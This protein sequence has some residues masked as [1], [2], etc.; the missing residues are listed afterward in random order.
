M[1]G[2]QLDV[3]SAYRSKEYQEKVMNEIIKEKG[4]EYARKYVAVPGY[5]EHQTG[6]AID[7]C[8]KRGN[9]FIY[10]DDLLG[11]GVIEFIEENA[12]K[13]GF[14]LRYPKGKENIT[15]YNYEPWHLR[16]VGLKLADYLYSKDITL[17]EY[18]YEKKYNIVDEYINKISKL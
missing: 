5:S 4:I 18:Y 2:F 14:I 3:D 17:E 13:F 11:T 15:K 10:D 7:I 1:N 8:L 6:L 9:D 12:H 16:Y